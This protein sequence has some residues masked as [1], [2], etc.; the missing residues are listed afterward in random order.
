MLNEP[1]SFACRAQA[2]RLSACVGRIVAL[3]FIFVVYSVS[4]WSQ[5]EPKWPDTP[6]GEEVRLMMGG[7]FN[8]GNRYVYYEVMKTR[9][10]RNS[11]YIATIYEAPPGV[12]IVDARFKLSPDGLAVNKILVL[13]SNKDV[14]LIE[15][16]ES[17][18]GEAIKLDPVPSGEG[19]KIIGDDLYIMTFENVFVS[20]S[21]YN[22]QI[23]TAGLG[24]FNYPKDIQVDA[25]QKVWLAT[26]NGLFTQEL[27]ATVWIKNTNYPGEQFA[28]EA[29]H[30]VFVDRMQHVWVSYGTQ[31]R[32]SFNGGQNFQVAPTGLSINF[33]RKMCDDAF[34]NVYVMCDSSVFLSR[35]G[36]QPFVRIDMPVI[37]DFALFGGGGIYNDVFGDTLISLATDAGVYTSANQGE[38]WTYDGS[39]RAEHINSVSETGDDRLLITSNAGLFRLEGQSNWTKRYPQTGFVRGSKVFTARNNDIYLHAGIV[40][41]SVDN[42]DSFLP[43]TAGMLAAGVLLYNFFADDAGVQHASA[44]VGDKLMVWKKN[45]GS[46][47]ELDDAGLPSTLNFDFST[48]CFGSNNNSKVYIAIKSSSSGMTTVYSRPTS[49]GVWASEIV[50]NGSVFNVKGRNGIVTMASSA[51]VKYDNGSGWQTVPLPSGVSTSVDWCLSEIDNNGVLWGYYETFDPN[52]GVFGG[53]RGEGIYSTDD[54]LTW[55]ARGVDTILIADLVAIG[56]SV[57]ALTSGSNGVYVVNTDVS[58]SVKN[59]DANQGAVNVHPNPSTGVFVFATSPNATSIK[60]Y[61]VVGVN[62]HSQEMNASNTSIDLSAHPKGVYYYQL[63]NRG[64]TV[65]TGTI[66][67][68]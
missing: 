42:G 66:I 65:K 52:F 63:T 17:D 3:L 38:T 46:P 49:G 56:D 58:S 5:E 50:I 53:S 67:V 68:E 55:T 27:D 43:D 26:D 29:C 1:M 10:L 32:V 19:M 14:V 57:F 48:S 2:G 40:Y 28:P 62:I 60:I 54:F 31:L 39:A 23:D 16:P 9:I 13:L 36:T 30:T 20:D 44:L 15:K 7:H 22:W 64:Q 6:P 51:G 34:G 4:T 47:W 24:E 25:T 18:E 8:D 37:T 33:I 61:N 11:A 41:K 21:G 45:P 59:E 35:G 12:D